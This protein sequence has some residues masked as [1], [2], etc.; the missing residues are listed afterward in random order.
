[1]FDR[2]LQNLG[3][4]SSDEVYGLE[5]ALPLGGRLAVQSLVKLKIE[6]HLT[7]LRQLGRP[8]LTLT[9]TELKDLMRR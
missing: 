5:P 3:P 9:K 7:I 8:N 4:L 2:A 1:M 6:Q